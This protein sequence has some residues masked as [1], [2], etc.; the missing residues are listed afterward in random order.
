VA[1]LRALDHRRDLARAKQG[2]GRDHHPPAFST[3]SHAA[4]I[5]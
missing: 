5:V 3:P 4:N 2:H 1:D